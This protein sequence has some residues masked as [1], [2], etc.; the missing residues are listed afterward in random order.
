MPPTKTDPSQTTTGIPE[1]AGFQEPSISAPLALAGGQRG[2][3]MAMVAGSAGG[4]SLDGGGLAPDGG[5]PYLDGQADGGPGP[6]AD[7]GFGNADT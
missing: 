4:G 3:M 6:G 5:A 7:V 2:P 1:R